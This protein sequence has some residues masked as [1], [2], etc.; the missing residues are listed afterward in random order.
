MLIFYKDGLASK[1]VAMNTE[2]QVGAKV[3]SDL[4]KDNARFEVSLK[5]QNG[6]EVITVRQ[7]VKADASS[8][9][10]KIAK[11]LINVLYRTQKDLAEY[12]GQC[13]D[14]KTDQ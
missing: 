1:P 10:Q 12:A 9:P 13:E 14:E 7:D 5:F 6:G 2:V 11:N 8:D 3:P 4:A